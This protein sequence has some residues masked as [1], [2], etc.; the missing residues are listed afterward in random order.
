MKAI[1]VTM[2]K[3][4]LPGVYELDGDTLKLCFPQSEKDTRPKEVKA[5][6]KG[7]SLLTLKRVKDEKKE[8][9]KK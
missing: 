7:V 1:D 3:L 6:E 2:D 9:P 4:T 8:E 5:E